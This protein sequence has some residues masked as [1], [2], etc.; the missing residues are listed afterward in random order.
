MLVLLALEVLVN[1][2]WDFAVALLFSVLDGY[3]TNLNLLEELNS[4]SIG[5]D[6]FSGD[7]LGCSLRCLK[8]T[9]SGQQFAVTR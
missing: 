8:F 1:G 7:C 2:E 9:S 5:V 6:D 3:Y 4:W